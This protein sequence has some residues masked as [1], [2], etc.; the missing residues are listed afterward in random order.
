MVAL[1]K[2][3]DRRA[4]P[5]SV[6]PPTPALLEAERDRN[7]YIAERERLEQRSVFRGLIVLAIV[8]LL[9]SMWRAGVD[10]VFIGRW[11][12]P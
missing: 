1:P 6:P 10:R 9:F 11:W 12:W 4:A 8:V 2:P 3:D 5:P 7:E